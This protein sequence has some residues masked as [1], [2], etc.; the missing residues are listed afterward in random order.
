MCRSN[1][2]FFFNY[3]VFFRGDHGP[4]LNKIG[5]CS[6]RTK[7]RA[8]NLCPISGQNERALRTKIRSDQKI[9]KKVILICPKQKKLDRWVGPDRWPKKTAK[10]R[11]R[12]KMMN[13]S[14]LQFPG[15]LL[16]V[17]WRWR[18]LQLIHCPRRGNWKGLA[19]E[20]RKSE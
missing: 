3:W 5:Q 10:N 18:K 7:L 14:F 6:E 19:E 20:G 1:W 13:S 8:E 4:R 17:I 9:D 15:F 12:A 16:L 2:C 11:G